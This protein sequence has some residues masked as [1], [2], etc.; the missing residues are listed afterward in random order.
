MTKYFTLFF[1]CVAS[2]GFA[3][4]K[5]FHVFE[6]QVDGTSVIQASTAYPDNAMILVYS[7]IENLD[8]RSSVGG[9]NQQRYNQR[10]SRYEILVTP[11]RQI[12]FVAARGFIEQRI[13]L[14][15]PEPKAVF[16]YQVEERSG[17]DEMA[18]FFTVKPDNARLYVNNIP[19]DI[20]KTVNVPSGEV[21]VRIEREGYRTINEPLTISPQ[22]VNYVYEMKEVD[23]EVVHIDANVQG[24]R[25]V[26]DGLEKGLTDANGRYSLF[27]YSGD[28]TVELQRSGYLSHKQTIRVFEGKVNTYKFDLEKNTGRLRIFT[29]HE[30]SEVFVNRRSYNNQREIELAPGRY[31]VE[32]AHDNY[33]SYFETID[34]ERGDQI[35]INATLTPHTGVLQFTVSPSHADVVL[36]TTDGELISR[37]QGINLLRNLMVGEYQLEIT[38]DGHIPQTLSVKINRDATE[39]MEVTLEEGSPMSNYEIAPFRGFRR[40][41]IQSRNWLLVPP[42]QNCPKGF[43]R[44]THTSVRSFRS[45]VNNSDDRIL[46][47]LVREQEAAN[48]I[49]NCFCVRDLASQRG[50]TTL[51]IYSVLAVVVLTLGE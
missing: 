10:A 51:L 12:I 14:I 17:Q 5:E 3:Q 16:Y 39:R 18:V 49:N 50:W 15:S 28:Y 36:K 20:N 31:R 23:L 42:Y 48:S 6:R 21:K 34:I 1:L 47:E 29:M 37:W 32:V 2:L 8:F 44:P 25:V 24:A 4:L 41:R 22:Q 45:Y 26:I 19:K 27:L 38:A 35:S 43:K 9:I 33:D 46:I 13:A 7:D 30:A 11:Q 40:F